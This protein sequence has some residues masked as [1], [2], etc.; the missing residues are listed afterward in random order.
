MSGGNI[1]FIHEYEYRLLYYAYSNSCWRIRFILVV[2]KFLFYKFKASWIRISKL[3]IT[4]V[5]SKQMLN[6]FLETNEFTKLRIPES[7]LTRMQ[8]D[9]FYA[10][11]SISEI[12]VNA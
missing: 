5:E 6:A 4:K 3:R 2:M 12:Y 7:F 1:L 9:R 8:Y 11:L 10:I